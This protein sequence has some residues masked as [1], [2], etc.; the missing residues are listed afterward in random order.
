[1][2]AVNAMLI[3][4]KHGAARST[5]REEHTMFRKFA[6]AAIA[7]AALA[8]ATFATTSTAQAG[9]HGYG[10]G[11]HYGY[12]KVYRPWV[13]VPVCHKVVRYDYWGNAYWTRSCH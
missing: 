12:V 8:G 7:A 2:H 9:W 13:Y 6:S 1:M 4:S 11:H 5:T 10:Y 3:P